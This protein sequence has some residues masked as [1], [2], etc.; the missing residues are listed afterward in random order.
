MEIVRRAAGAGVQPRPHLHRQPN[1]EYE[2]TL[3]DRQQSSRC[4]QPERTYPNAG[5]RRG[6]SE[7]IREG[8]THPRAVASTSGR[9]WSC[10]HRRKRGVL[11]GMDYLVTR[12]G[13][14][15]DYDAPAGPRSC[16]D[17]FDQLKSRSPAATHPWT[18]S[19]TESSEADL[20][21][22]RHP[23]ATPRQVDA[24]SGD[25][26]Q[27]Q[28]LRATAVEM[29]EQA[30]QG[31]HSRASSSWWRSRPPS[32]AGSSPARRSRPSARTCSPSATAATSPASGS[33]WRSRRK[34]RSA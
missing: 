2:V 5:D 21:K 8:A 18:T 32:A 9:S 28:G 23:D 13:S 12:T 11:R 31:A 14:R 26:A 29:A 33:S 27:G 30:A 25:R 19:P 17:F 34:A 6:S 10:A 7:P 16:F 15:C 24:F 22:A 4:D 3:E 1:V 20:V